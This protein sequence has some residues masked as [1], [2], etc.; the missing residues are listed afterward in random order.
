MNIK[1]LIAANLLATLLYLI[2]LT[3]RI[4]T[5]DGSE[6]MIQWCSIT[7]SLRMRKEDGEDATISIKPSV[8]N[9]ILIF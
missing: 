5:P 6:F 1:H 2:T 3:T 9:E 4:L 7:N 8:S